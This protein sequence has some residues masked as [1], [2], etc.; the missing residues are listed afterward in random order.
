VTSC[1]DSN[2]RACDTVSVIDPV[3]TIL[4]VFSNSFSL[5]YLVELIATPYNTVAT[6]IK[7]DHLTLVIRVMDPEVQL[8]AW[9]DLIIFSII[10]E[11][12]LIVNVNT[13]SNMVL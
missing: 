9:R 4:I 8:F 13:P 6:N 2:I 11:P 7:I 3:E 5:D 12:K 1:A 10:V